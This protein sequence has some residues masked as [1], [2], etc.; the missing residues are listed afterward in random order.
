MGRQTMRILA[1]VAVAG[2]LFASGG[3]AAAA[4]ETHSWRSFS[5]GWCLDAKYDKELQRPVA[6]QAPCNPDLWAQQWTQ[7]DLGNGYWMLENFAGCLRNADGVHAQPPPEDRI[8]QVVACD[9]ANER[10]WW[11]QVPRS[12]EW[13]L[14]PRVPRIIGGSALCLS[15]LSPSS[16]GRMT[17]Q[18]CAPE[19]SIH[20]S[21]VKIQ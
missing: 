1:M 9:R 2:V 15:A 6:T 4:D 17:T 21:W 19:N 12:G 10:L 14:R 18:D 16:N 13:T 5:T 20:A 3:T 11:S 8:V 7:R